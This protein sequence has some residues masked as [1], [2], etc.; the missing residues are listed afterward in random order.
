[1]LGSR[2]SQHSVHASRASVNIHSD[3]DDIE[4]A[5]LQ[6]CATAK[7]FVRR[8][9]RLR[10]LRGC[11]IGSTPLAGRHCASLLQHEQRALQ[12][13]QHDVSTHHSRAAMHSILTD[14]EHAASPSSMAPSEEIGF[15]GQPS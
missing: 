4:V 12:V 11:N 2:I 13:H 8:Q 15:P 3:Q 14:V 7:R 6:P 9:G 10:Y 1:M 5:G